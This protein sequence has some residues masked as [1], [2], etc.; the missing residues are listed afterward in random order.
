MLVEQKCVVLEEEAL[1]KV[2]SLALV[3]VDRRD[4]Q[5]SGTQ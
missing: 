2:L 5:I 4:A 1:I 3:L